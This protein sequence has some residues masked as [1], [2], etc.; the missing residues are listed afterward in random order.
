MVPGPIATVPSIFAHFRTVPCRRHKTLPLLAHHLFVVFPFPVYLKVPTRALVQQETIGVRIDSSA[1]S[2]PRYRSSVI[3]VRSGI[4]HGHTFE[5]QGS[6]VFMVP[7]PVAAAHSLPALR[8]TV[9]PPVQEEGRILTHLV[10][11]VDKS[12]WTD[13]PLLQS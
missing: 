7:G 1:I 4:G 6:R 5:G 9:L 13:Q 10:I 12:A 8:G 11:Q 3:K 2:T